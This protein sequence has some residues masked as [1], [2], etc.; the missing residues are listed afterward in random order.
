MS[1]SSARTFDVV[2]CCRGDEIHTTKLEMD[3]FGGG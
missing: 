1:Q 3:E 2:I